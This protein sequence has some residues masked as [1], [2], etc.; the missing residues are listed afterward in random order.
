MTITPTLTTRNAS[1]SDLAAMLQQRQARRLDVVASAPAIRSDRGTIVVQ[2]TEPIITDDG[3][4]DGDGRYQPT[5]IADE[6]IAEKLGIPI[7]YLRRMREQRPDLL[8]ANI[9]GWLHGSGVDAAESSYGDPA[10]P[11][12]RKFLLRCFRSDDGGDGVLRAM[13]SDSYRIMDDFDVLTAALDG[14]R[15]SGAEVE[16]HRCDLTDRR[17]YVQVEAPAV[18]VV[19]D[20]LLDGYRS[21]FS[22]ESGTDNPLVHAGFRI[23]NSEVGSGAFQI[24]PELTVQVCT[25]GMTIT[26]DAMRAV[27]LGGRMDEGL[28]RWTADTDRKLVALVAAQAR[29]AVATFLDPEYVRRIVDHITEQAGTRLSDPAATIEHVGRKLGYTEEQRA[30]IL[31]HFIEGGQLT[32]GGVLHAVTSYARIVPDADAA[33]ELSTSALDALALAAA[34]E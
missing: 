33:W 10:P 29:D 18:A 23:V 22:G 6:G 20:A 12:G 4:S 14:V 25:N 7:R 21:P 27:H 11:D 30:G 31:N 9:N 28:V 3:V 34:A 17:M 8:D 16:V 2:G 1:L 19:A 13:L 5:A 26:K 15:Q 32:S 24:V